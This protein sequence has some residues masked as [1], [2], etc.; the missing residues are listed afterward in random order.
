MDPDR[1]PGGEID[2]QM[3]SDGSHRDH[4]GIGEV[5]DLV[6]DHTRQ[7]LRPAVRHGIA[8]AGGYE[9]ERRTAKRN[10][11]GDIIQI[12]DDGYKDRQPLGSLSVFRGRGD[13][14]FYSRDIFGPEVRWMTLELSRS[15]ITFRYTWK[16]T[17][18]ESSES[19]ATR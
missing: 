19:V 8:G 6:D 12:N 13:F 1:E 2:D 9:R 15:G 10:A 18:E 11:F 3:L 4:V 14:V 5:A 16:F 17:D 7:C